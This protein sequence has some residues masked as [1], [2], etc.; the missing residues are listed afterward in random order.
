MPFFFREAKLIH[1]VNN[2]GFNTRRTNIKNLGSLISVSLVCF[3][4]FYFSLIKKNPSG[5]SSF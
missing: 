2:N 4:A 1:F 5:G 3:V